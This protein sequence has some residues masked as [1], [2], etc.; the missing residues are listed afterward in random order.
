MER[1]LLIAGL[2]GATWTV[3]DPLLATGRVQ[4]VI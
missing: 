3:L 2:D 4:M 1:Q